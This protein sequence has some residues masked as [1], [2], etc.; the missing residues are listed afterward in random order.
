MQTLDDLIE[1]YRKMSTIGNVLFPKNQEMAEISNLESKEVA[2]C[3]EELKAYRANDGMSEN[4]YRMGHKFGYKKAIDDFKNALTDHGKNVPPT[5]C[6]AQFCE[7]KCSDCI[8]EIRNVANKL[9]E[10][11]R[12]ED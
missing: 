9:K 1:K 8:V 6:K 12:N 2:D 3:L 11:K 10:E 4:V 7:G 5:H